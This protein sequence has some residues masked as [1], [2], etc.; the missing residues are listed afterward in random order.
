MVYIKTMNWA[1]WL[2]VMLILA[3]VEIFTVNLV[4]L[5]F[6]GGAAAG[7]I[8]AYLGLDIALQ[9]IVAIVVAV[10]MLFLVRPLFLKSL[11]PALEHRTNVDAL[12]GAKA[13]TLEVVTERA[14]T[15]RLAGEVW[16]ARSMGTDIPS[17]CEVQVLRID[18]ATA[19]VAPLKEQA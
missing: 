4:F 5:M 8:A 19:V 1:L 14:G 2:A 12:L 16:S 7:A 15:V 13:L 9:F 18:G 10:A 11:R 6:A 3:M 17:D